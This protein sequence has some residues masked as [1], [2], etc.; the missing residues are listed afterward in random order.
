MD[1]ENV[2]ELNFNN[3]KIWMNEQ[4][5]RIALVKVQF[6]FLALQYIQT[7]SFSLLSFSFTNLWFSCFL[8]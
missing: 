3:A 5:K 6:L 2:A 8:S 7:L 4:Q 1:W